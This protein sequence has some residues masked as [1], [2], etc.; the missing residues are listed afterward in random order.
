MDPLLMKFI[1]DTTPEMNYSVVN[2]LA[3]EHLKYTIQYIDGI[4]RNVF[5]DLLPG[6][7]YVRLV[8][9][10]PEE[11]LRKE[12]RR[13]NNKLVIDLAKSDLYLVGLDFTYV[14]PTKTDPVTGKPDLTEHKLQRRYLFLPFAGPAGS[15][16][17]S[18][19]RFFISTVLSDIV[20]SYE[21][22]SI[23]V[24]LLRDKFAVKRVDHTVYVNNKIETVPVIWSEI[25]HLNKDRRSQR[26]SK[27]LCPLF[28][29]LMCQYGLSGAL[30]KYTGADCVIGDRDSITSKSHPDEEWSV[31]E[32]SRSLRRR[33]YRGQQ[34][35]VDFKIAVPKQQANQYVHSLVGT[36]FY[37]LDYF[38][39]KFTEA[40]WLESKEKWMII[41]GFIYFGENE[42][43]GIILEDIREH[44]KSLDEY[45][46]DII[47]DKLH[48]IGIDVTDIYDLLA[49]IIDR[50]GE[51]MIS[52]SDRINSLYDKEMSILYDTLFPITSSIFNCFFK[53]K[54]A[55]KSSQKGLSIRDI[56]KIMDSTIRARTI[57]SITKPNNGVTSMTYSGDN[58]FFKI[59]SVLN[60]QKRTSG[61]GSGNDAGQLED[62]EKR[63]HVS[64]VD[65][66]NYSNLTGKTPVGSQRVNPYVQ[67]DKR[68]RVL[69]SQRSREA[70]DRTQEMIK[71]L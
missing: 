26:T 45:M 60:P 35:Y 64:F 23:F 14:D 20:I 68:G 8:R 56:E 66:G 41:M 17:L 30:K 21:R 36:I 16:T 42:H 40:S 2:G 58:K 61:R 3:A 34:Q 44:F 65:V 37:L 32:S 28:L 62:P 5:K 71:R 70:L 27:A 4:V 7:K 24:R 11:E 22:E 47:R 63:L 67:V 52:T 6:L 1:K 39:D 25:Y 57:F 55:A 18:G 43:H 53:L 49:I 50:F 69:K 59:T 51:W 12:Q 46:D 31:F 15:I 19:S 13:K 54:S 9:C 10:S 48:S 33:G 38:P 29:Y